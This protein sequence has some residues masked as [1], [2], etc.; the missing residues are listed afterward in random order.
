MSSSQP[1]SSTRQNE[2]AVEW[3]GRSGPQGSIAALRQLQIARDVLHPRIVAR[4]IGHPNIL[5]LGFILKV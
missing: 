2:T 4:H 3:S 5:D 1:L